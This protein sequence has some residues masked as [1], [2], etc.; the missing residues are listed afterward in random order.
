M[1]ALG[2]GLGGCRVSANAPAREMLGQPLSSNQDPRHRRSELQDLGQILVAEDS[3]S[4][5]KV[6]LNPLKIFSCR[7]S[8]AWSPA[9][10]YLYVQCDCDIALMDCQMPVLD[11]Y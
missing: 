1:I 2:A 4:G 5:G 3:P 9:V 11:G 7:E 8:A 10:L 6:T